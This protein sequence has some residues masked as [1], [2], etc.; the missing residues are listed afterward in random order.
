[1]YEDANTSRRASPMLR[2]S[3]LKLFFVIFVSV[4]VKTRATV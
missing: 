3:V 4:V 2:S 1:M